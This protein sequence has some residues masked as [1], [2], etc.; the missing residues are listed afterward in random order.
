NPRRSESLALA[1]T[2]QPAQYG[3]LFARGSDREARGARWYGAPDAEARSL[4]RPRQAPGHVEYGRTQAK[5]CGVNIISEAA[6]GNNLSPRTLHNRALS[7][8]A[9]MR[10]T[11]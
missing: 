1:R 4:P 10:C 8:N 9:V 7:I 5:L 11:A 2:R 6:V 3:G